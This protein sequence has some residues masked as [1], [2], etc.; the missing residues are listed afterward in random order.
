MS[1]LPTAPIRWSVTVAIINALRTHSNL[2]GV[3][4]EPGWPGDE[5]LQPEAIWVDSLDGDL[6]TPVFKG[7]RLMYDD[8]FRIPFEI[9]VAN[10]DTLDR[11]ASRLEEVV[12]GLVDTLQ[13]DPS[14]NDYPGVIAATISS[15]R[16]TMAEHDSGYIGFAEV[17]VSIHS[18]I[19]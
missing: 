6:E 3:Q 2:V 10:R 13:T 17:V 14:L 7:Q 8:M 12:G 9:R 16:S 15:A 4:V 1:D 5:M 18:R 11:T 19:A